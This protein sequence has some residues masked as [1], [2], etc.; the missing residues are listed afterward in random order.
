MPL[1]AISDPTPRLEVL[2]FKKR[3]MPGIL[4][5]RDP[6]PSS[7][8]SPSPNP[9][10]F[11]ASS[12]APSRI[13]HPSPPTRRR[14]LG[15]GGCPPPPASPALHSRDLALPKRT[16]AGPL[17]GLSLPCPRW[18]GVPHAAA[19]GPLFLG[20]GGRFGPMGGV[21]GAEWQDGPH[22]VPRTQS[23]SLRGYCG[24]R[25]AKDLAGRPFRFFF[26]SNYEL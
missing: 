4:N 26:S 1:S 10:P 2:G 18:R 3:K 19:R 20:R 5:H 7:Q 14:H 21:T 9:E 12:Q 16:G 22:L 24:G 15:T 13:P 8:I 11:R 6:D 17:L 23:A 25:P